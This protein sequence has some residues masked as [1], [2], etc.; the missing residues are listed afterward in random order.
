MSVS[1]LFIRVLA[2]IAVLLLCTPLAIRLYKYFFPE[3][4]PSVI[5]PPARR[6]TPSPELVAAAAESAEDGEPTVGTD[7]ADEVGEDAEE[8]AEEDGDDRFRYLDDAFRTDMSEVAK[9]VAQQGINL[10]LLASWVGKVYATEDFTGTKAEFLQEVYQLFP[11]LH[12]LTAELLAELD[13]LLAR[14]QFATAAGL[15]WV[16]L[17]GQEALQT[18]QLSR[19]ELANAK[20]AREQGD[21]SYSVV[22]G[23]VVERRYALADYEEDDDETDDE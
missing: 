14:Q 13:D 22:D 18:E 11:D 7:D 9:H 21:Y 5:V 6:P 1:D 20:K 8:E 19:I 23:Q 12:L 4:Q 17:A 3:P 2:V 10:D 15:A 16:C